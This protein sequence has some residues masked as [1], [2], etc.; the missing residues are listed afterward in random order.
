MQSAALEISVFPLDVFRI[1]RNNSGGEANLITE[2][3]SEEPIMTAKCAC[4]G[5]EYPLQ[6]LK[7]SPKTEK[8]IAELVFGRPQENPSDTE[9]KQLFCPQCYSRKFGGSENAD[10]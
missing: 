4:C 5:K 1:L 9:M 7:F 10:S 8:H 3:E 2:T 6:D